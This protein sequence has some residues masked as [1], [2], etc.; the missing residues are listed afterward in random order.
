VD[1]DK[2]KVSKAAERSMRVF[3]TSVFWEQ[4]METNRTWVEHCYASS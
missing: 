3:I 1:T 2:T 4:E